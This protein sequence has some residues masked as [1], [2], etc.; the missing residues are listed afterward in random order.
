[1]ELP[2]SRPSGGEGV[3]SVLGACPAGSSAESTNLMPAIPTI[4]TAIYYHYYYNS[5]SFHTDLYC[6]LEDKE[7]RNVLQ[8][9]LNVV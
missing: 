4:I 5:F 3:L 6:S 2:S 9:G 1:V 8:G 7:R